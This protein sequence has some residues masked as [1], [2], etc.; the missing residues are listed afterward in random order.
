MEA[1]PGKRPMRRTVQL[2]LELRARRTTTE[3]KEFLQLVW[4]KGRALNWT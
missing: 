4:T 2:G 3:I 1:H